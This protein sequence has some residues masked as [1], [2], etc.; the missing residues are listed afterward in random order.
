MGAVAAANEAKVAAA[1]KKLNAET[2]PAGAIVQ[3]VDRKNENPGGH[4]S[5]GWCVSL[6]HYGNRMGSYR[7]TP[8]YIEIVAMRDNSWYQFAGNQYFQTA[9]GSHFYVDFKRT[10]NGGGEKSLAEELR[11]SSITDELTG[12]HPSRRIGTMVSPVF[13]DQKAKAKKSQKVRYT[14]WVASWNSG[15]VYLDGHNSNEQSLNWY[16]LSEIAQ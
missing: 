5:N 4:C 13:L 16:T 8:L 10:V 12:G 3:V 7:K 6:P 2:L 9:G 14:L 1:S 15:R 11:Q